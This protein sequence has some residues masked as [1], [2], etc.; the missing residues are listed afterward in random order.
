MVYDIELRGVSINVQK[1]GMTLGQTGQVAKLFGR[2]V[3][4]LVLLGGLGFY[5]KL[6]KNYVANSQN[7]TEENISE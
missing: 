2:I 6:L 5:Q 4:H 1:L 7:Q 3:I